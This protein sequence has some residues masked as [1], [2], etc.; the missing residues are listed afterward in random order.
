MAGSVFVEA[1]PRDAEIAVV[2]GGVAGMSTA[3]FL[4]RAGRD[5][6]LLERGV[7]WGDASGANAGTLSLQVKRT[8][9]LDLCKLSLAVWKRFGDEMGDQVRKNNWVVLPECTGVWRLTL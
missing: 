8:E 3:L 6:V 7:P 2:G 5:V 9:V 4:A 1:P